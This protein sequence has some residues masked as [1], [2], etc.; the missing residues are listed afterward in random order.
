MST[1]AAIARTPAQAGAVQAG[2][3]AGGAT[4]S[5]QLLATQ[6]AADAP[7]VA[8]H[9]RHLVAFACSG[10]GKARFGRGGRVAGM[11][12]MAGELAML[13]CVTTYLLSSIIDLR[14]C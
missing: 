13:V 1:Y 8:I 10:L 2:A 11:A 9:P 5:G 4:G 3:T 14:M 6:L 12:G 7:A